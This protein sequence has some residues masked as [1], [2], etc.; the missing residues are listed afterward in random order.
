MTPDPTPARAGRTLALYLAG[1][2]VLG[3]LTGVAVVWLVPLASDSFAAAVLRKGPDTVVKR[4]LQ[5]WAV[6][7]LPYL[8][9]GL[10]WRGWRDIGLFPEEAAVEHGHSLRRLFQGFLL[11]VATM[12]PMAL[13]GYALGARVVT[14]GRVA[15]ASVRLLAGYA[16]SAVVVGAFEEILARG[17]LFRVPARIWGARRAAIVGGLLFGVAHFLDPAEAAFRSP[18]FVPAV[19]AVLKSTFVEIGR[20]P[21]LLL[22]WLN[23]ALLGIVLCAFVLRTG[24]IWFSIGAHAGW[25][26]CIRVSQR[27]SESRPAAASWWGYRADATD[28]P[29]TAVLLLLLLAGALWGRRRRRGGAAS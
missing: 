1:V 26:W 14:A 21:D 25:V 27:L 15:S 6:L 8:F 23:L 11:G 22:R 28:S 20:T 24:T 4:A 5:V 16:L 29:A 7:L 9:K 10:G 17:I 18:S 13:A 19:L 12:G 3:I 2:L